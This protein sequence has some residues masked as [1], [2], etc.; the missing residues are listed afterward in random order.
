MLGFTYV[1]PNLRYYATPHHFGI[2]IYGRV[3]Y[4]YQGIMP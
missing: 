2:I 1:Q 4:R 3:P